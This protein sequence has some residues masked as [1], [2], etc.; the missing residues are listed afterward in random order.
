MGAM[1]LRSRKQSTHQAWPRT[2]SEWQ[3]VAYV[4]ILASLADTHRMMQP[5]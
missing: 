3:L 2:Q 4:R 5:E 1:W